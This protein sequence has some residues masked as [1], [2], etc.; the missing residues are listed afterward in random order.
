MFI[1]DV[2]LNIQVNSNI[3]NQNSTIYRFLLYDSNNKLYYLTSY[4][5]H[6]NPELSK[7]T[8]NFNG[9]INNNTSSYYQ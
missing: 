4:N 7:V 3:I 8:F 5:I 6:V 2:E 1:F 9:N